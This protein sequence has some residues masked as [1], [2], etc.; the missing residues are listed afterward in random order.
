VPNVVGQ[1]LVNARRLIA[2]AGLQLGPVAVDSA[3][4]ALPNTVLLQDPGAGETASAGGAVRIT[5]AGI[6]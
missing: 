4:V 2:A 6:R 5:V 3:A 1:P